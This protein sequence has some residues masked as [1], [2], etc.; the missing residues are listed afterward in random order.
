MQIVLYLLIGIAVGLLIACVGLLVFT[1]ITFDEILGKFADPHWGKLA[2]AFGTAIASLVV[3]VLVLVTIHEGGHLVCGLLSGY[4]FVSFRIFNFTVVRVDGR[5]KVKRYSV[6]GTGGQCLLDPPHLP[7]PLIP[8]GWYNAGGVLA[9]LIVM[10]IVLPV[11][12]LGNM[13]P[14]VDAALL[15]FILVNGIM[16]LTNGIPMRAGGIANDAA[17]VL[18]LRH[19]MKAKRGIELMLRS[20]ALLQEGV[21]PKDMPEEWFVTDGIINYRNPLETGVPSMAASRLVDEMRWEEAYEAFRNLYD[22]RAEI[23]PLY[24]KEIACE[25][26]FTSMVTGRIEEATQLLDKNLKAYIE[27]Y[28]NI[29]SAKERMLCAIA[30]YLEHDREKAEDIYK[31]VSRRVDEYLLQGEVKSDIAVM[32]HMLGIA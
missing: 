9:Q 32:R 1:D 3:S 10:A 18:Y 13:H 8:M 7:T 29:S 26:A 22:H 23:M 31:R 28:R 27:N 16:I 21:R 19:D 24:V 5:L 15:I 6:A 12:I 30:L 14:L 25:L 17:N 4:R 2:A 20:N 11:F